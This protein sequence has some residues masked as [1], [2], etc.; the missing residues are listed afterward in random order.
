MS[1]VGAA[2]PDLGP[3]ALP[4]LRFEAPPP[5]QAVAE[6]LAAT[7]RSRLLRV[8]AMTGL[9]DPGPPIRVLVVPEDNAAAQQAPSWVV[10]YALG[11]IG[12]VVLLPARVPAY[13]DPTIESV[14]MHEVAHVLIARAA[15]RRP[16]P[17]WF[18]EGVAMAASRFGLR[19]R[20]ELVFATIR[21][22]Q[23]SLADLDDA[24]PAGAG[25]AGRAYALSGAVVR[26]MLDTYG[27]GVV[28]RVLGGVGAGATFEQ[29][30]LNAT[31]TSIVNAETLFWRR[32]TFWHQ[33]VPFL[34]SSTFL[35][36]TITMLF[37]VAAQRR[38]V[39]NQE[40]EARWEAEEAERAL[41]VD[42][43]WVN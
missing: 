40:I 23:V 3:V 9:R 12:T 27:D 24:F 26:W 25:A 29:A 10:G 20:T 4:E 28:S 43:S 14:L 35:W 34:G 33:W 30:F 22:R 16:I 39:R 21:R 36:L 32:N 2:V 13:P 31:G 7:D 8:V 38:R 37:L 42:E 19:D 6:R 1:P 17:R 18:N 41:V 5:L 11:A 15:R